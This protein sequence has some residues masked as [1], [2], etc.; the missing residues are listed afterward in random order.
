[1]NRQKRIGIDLMGGDALPLELADALIDAHQKLSGCQFVIFALEDLAVSLA[2]KFEKYPVTIVSSS[3]A[4][5]PEDKPLKAIRKKLDS[6]LMKGISALQNK[7]IDA[8]ISCGNTG[9]LLAAS[10]LNLP[11]FPHVK[12]PALLA[13]FPSSH[14]LLT[15]LDVGGQV[16]ATKEQLIQF[17]FL[18]AAYNQVRHKTKKPKVALLNIGVESEKGTLELKSAFQALSELKNNPSFE[19]IGNIEPSKIF[20]NHVDVVVTSGFA[21]NVFLKTAE[22]ISAFVLAQVEKKIIKDQSNAFLEL[23]LRLSYEESHGALI[24]GLDAIVI[25]CHGAASKRSLLNAIL[26]ASSLLEN[27]LLTQMKQ[28]YNPGRDNF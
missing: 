14:G 8:F 20:E 10:T 4:I 5:L 18:G 7:E 15:V 16:S 2:K 23:K 9:A 6:S 25:K 12:R 3:D 19:F 27:N 13:E 17:A 1:M 22:G 26:G 24:A 21:G 11:H 28:Y